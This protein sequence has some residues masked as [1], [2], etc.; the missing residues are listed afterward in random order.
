[1]SSAELSSQTIDLACDEEIV[2]PHFVEFPSIHPPDALK[3]VIESQGLI[4]HGGGGYFKETDR[5]PAQLAVSTEGTLE[6]IDNEIDSKNTRNLSSLITVMYTP[7]APLGKF[8]KLKSRSIHILQKGKGQVVLLYPDG[9]IKSFKVGY[10]YQNGEISQ[11]VVPDG[12]Y[13]ACFLLPNEEFDNGLLISEVVVP[14]FDF[15]D[16][17]LLSDTDELIKLVGEEKAEMLKGLM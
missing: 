13:K 9:R 5:S 3:K 12:V 15:S 16:C 8:L 6:G 4:N 10:D 11:W 7:N 1:M 14:G 17:D 2:L